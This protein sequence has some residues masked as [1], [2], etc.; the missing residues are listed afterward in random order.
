M[1]KQLTEKYD[2]E[3]IHTYAEKGE[4]EIQRL[5][6][7]RRTKTASWLHSQCEAHRKEWSVNSYS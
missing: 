6:R 7:C 1:A 4:S 2:V 3:R 5:R